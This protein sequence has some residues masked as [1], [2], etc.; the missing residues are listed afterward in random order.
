L[1][2]TAFEILFLN[3]EQPLNPISLYGTILNQASGIDFNSLTEPPSGIIKFVSIPNSNN[4]RFN[5][6]QSC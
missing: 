4:N 3:T 6:L 5:S 1:K 2:R